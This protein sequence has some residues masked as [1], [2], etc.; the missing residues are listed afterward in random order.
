DLERIV[1]ALGIRHVGEHVAKVLVRRFGS[2]ERL[3]EAGEEDLTSVREVGPEIAG[4]V[5]RF[6]RQEQNRGEI[7]RLRTVLGR[8]P[9]QP[10]VDA[11]GKRPLAGKSFVLTGTLSS[12]TR[13][14][15]G[16][17]LEA[18]GGKVSS[19]VS[20]KTDFVIAGEAPGSKAARARELGIP[21][22]TEK[23]FLKMIEV[24]REGG[25]E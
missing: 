13:E 22:L 14:E 5:A 1:F 12:M 6:F 7:S 18:L 25:P 21:L 10:V 17:R 4:S 9:V 3:M 8:F 2:M 15:A 20:S 24:T 19:G 16:R 23:E 11:P